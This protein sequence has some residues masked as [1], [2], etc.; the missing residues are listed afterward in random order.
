MSDTSHI[1][2]VNFSYY[3][4]ELCSKSSITAETASRKDLTLQGCT[5]VSTRTYALVDRSGR[6]KI[7]KHTPNGMSTGFRTRSFLDPKQAH[8][9]YPTKIPATKS[10]ISDMD[11]GCVATVVN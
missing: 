9:G 10:A 1:I 8:G 2:A 11:L 7:K 3:D 6:Y 4:R 5:K